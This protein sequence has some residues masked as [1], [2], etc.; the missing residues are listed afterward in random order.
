ML[1]LGLAVLF[2]ER[3][4][5]YGKLQLNIAQIL[6]Y[7]I[8]AFRKNRPCVS[9]VRVNFPVVM[10]ACMTKPKCGASENSFSPKKLQLIAVKL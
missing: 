8:K 2:R 7:V 10:K 3:N 9:M 1:H 4:S 6:C 5:A